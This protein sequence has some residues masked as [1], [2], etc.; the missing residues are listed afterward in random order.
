[1]KI[2]FVTPYLPSPPTFGGQMRLHG[3]MRDLGREH[4]VSV[5]SLV[6]PREDVRDATRATAAYCQ[7][8]TTVPNRRQGRASVL[9]RLLQLGTMLSTKSYERV[10]YYEPGMQGAVDRALAGE[11]FDVVQFE[12]CQMAVYARPGEARGPLLCLDEHNVEYDVVRRTAEAEVGPMRRAYSAVNW[13]KLKREERSA[14]RAFEGSVLTSPR[15]EQMLREDEP[16]ARTAVVPN[17]VDV[18]AFA[19]GS[20]PK[21]GDSVLFFGALNYY[22]NVDA[23]QFFLREIWPLVREAEPGARLS[24]VGHKAPPWVVSWPD[25]TVEVVG[26]VPDIR[27]HIA[28]AKVVVAPLR[29]GGGTRLKVLEAMSLATVVVST[30]VGAEGLDVR[31][32]EN[33]LI[34]DEARPFAAAVARALADPALGRRLGEAA[35]KVVVDHYSWHASTRRLLQFYE[36]L[37]AA[38]REAGPARR[39][40]SRP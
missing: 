12:C 36:E 18:E 34:A 4:E 1:V 30:T 11:A 14:W 26:F 22:P 29:I 8:V 10:A 40:R 19:P 32:G 23:L 28:R 27:P 7:R 6:D 33:I 3:L 13:R 35:R 39:R 20:L 24:I 9:K 31:D 5:V 21:D 37:R 2:L 25:P 15:D 17:G 38:R 16:G